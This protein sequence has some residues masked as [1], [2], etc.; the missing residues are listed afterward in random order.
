MQLNNMKIQLLFIGLLLNAANLY[1]GLFDMSNY[2]NNESRDLPDALV[3]QFDDWRNLSIATARQE[4]LDVVGNYIEDGKGFILLEVMVFSEWSD[5]GYTSIVI[6]P[7]FFNHTG[8]S[9]SFPSDLWSVASGMAELATFSKSASGYPISSLSRITLITYYNGLELHYA[10]FIGLEFLFKA[11]NEIVK[12][13]FG[14]E[15]AYAC[16]SLLVFL[17]KISPGVFEELYGESFDYYL[18]KDDQYSVID[19][20]RMLYGGDLR[21]A[22]FNLLYKFR[23]DGSSQKEMLRE[24]LIREYGEVGPDDIKDVAASEES[25]NQK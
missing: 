25:G 11:D 19:H 6:T 14:F 16:F 1:A 4:T 8:S 10:G 2:Y 7:D 24:F 13:F 5:V 22:L 21:R 17:E 18:L 20:L 3:A 23:E 12:R 9:R 15:R